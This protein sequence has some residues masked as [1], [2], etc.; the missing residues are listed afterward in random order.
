MLQLDDSILERLESIAGNA[1]LDAGV[2]AMRYYR[3]AFRKAAVLGVGA[4]AATEADVQ[5]TLAALRNLSTVLSQI[6]PHYR[7][8]GEELDV[9]YSKIEVRQRMD[10]EIPQLANASNVVRS[11]QDFV[12]TFPGRVCVLIDGLDGTT[13]FR[14]GLQLFCSALA[15]FVDGHLR[16]GAIYDP[17]HHVVYYGSLPEVRPRRAFKWSV[18]SG[19]NVEMQPTRGDGEL[20]VATHLTRSNASKRNEMIRKLDAVVSAAGAHYQLNSGQLALAYVAGGMLSGFANNST[21]TWDVA[22]GQV[23]V[24]AIGG[25]VTRFDGSRIAYAT[26]GKVEVVA[27]A[28]SSIHRR[29]LHLLK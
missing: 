20:L 11:G 3:E 28:T 26:P 10:A 27:G 12:T 14:A 23:L 19:E 13:N 9:G 18:A 7:L 6:D 15:M 2:A 24:E 1:V 4:N 8:Y 17:I 25:Q 5:A 29:L 22:A 21:N 16:V